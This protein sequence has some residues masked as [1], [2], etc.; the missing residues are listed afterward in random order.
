[1]RRV[2]SKVRLA[3][4]ATAVLMVTSITGCK[5]GYEWAEEKPSWLGESIYD[6]LQR[7]GEFSIFLQ[8]VTDL[9]RDEF[10]KK[11]GSVTVFAATDD[12]YRTYFAKRGIDA[13]NL[14][15]AQKKYLVNSAML[16]NA[17]VLDLLTNLSVT[18]GIAKGQVMRRTNTQWAVYD[19]ITTVPTA[20]LPPSTPLH[21]WWKRLRTM[22]Q[23]A[24]NIIA[25]GTQPMVHFLWR[26]MM[27]KGITPTDFSYLFGG[28]TFNEEDVY[29]NN[30]KVREGNITCQNGYIHIMDDVPTPLPSMAAY[31][32][33]N[34]HT[35]LFARLIDRFSIPLS[36]TDVA[37]QYAYLYDY[38][39]G[40]G[41]YSPLWGGD[42]IFYKGYLWRDALGNGITSV[43][44]E[45][46]TG[47]L[48][49]D[50][51][52]LDYVE[53]GIDEGVDMGAIFAPTD[54]A[55]L[56]WWEG[57]DGQ[58]LRQ[59]YP[60]DTPFDSVPD[61]VLAEFLNNHIQPSFLNSIPSRFGN[62]RDDAK[63]PI[64]LTTDAIVPDA[65]ATCCNGALYVMNEVY[66]PSSFRSVIAPTLV[67]DNMKIMD[68]AIRNLEFKPYLLSM[69]SY[70]NY[71][72]LTDEALRRYIDPVTYNTDDPRWFEFVYNDV[73][74]T[75]DAYTYS[76]DK[77]A[78]GDAAFTKKNMRPLTASEGVAHAAVRNRLTD[79]LN[80]TIIPR[81]IYGTNI[82]GPQTPYLITKDNGVM[83][84]VDKGSDLQIRDQVSGEYVTIEERVEKDNGYYLVA[85]HMV[86][87]TMLSL[88]MLL[89]GHEE[90]SEF[91]ELLLGNPEWTPAER[92]LYA[93][94][95]R[96]S[97]K[98][99][100]MNRDN[101]TV[102]TFNSYQYTVY[103]PD[104]DAMTKAYE[105]G[106]PRWSDINALTE[107]YAGRD[108]IDIAQLKH[109]YTMRLLNFIKYHLQDRSIYIGGDIAN[110]T[111]ET[112]AYVLEGTQEGL[113]YSLQVSSTPN[114]ITVTGNYIPSWTAPATVKST[115]APTDY[116]QSVREYTFDGESYSN[117]IST[118]SYAVVHRISEPLLYD[119]ECLCIEKE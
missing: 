18:D 91:Y 69:V 8:M 95:K 42:S 119:E 100:S 29:I 84:I 3:L 14:T 30:V 37:K 10:L 103:V 36:A 34:G 107:K 106:L 55:L 38:Y 19:S 15:P 78:E 40:Q 104:N 47:W 83:E 16:E 24:Y 17:Y 99:Y 32:A 57:D 66:A 28:K 102:K 76:Y 54:E 9:G 50:P 90:Y 51:G 52:R 2:I 82:V 6:E 77:T 88:Q 21:D 48:K 97:S 93:I 86:Q 53:S 56:A 46:A 13:D 73:Q 108:D 12:A 98:T 67:E 61:N 89:E 81:D 118:S 72:I 87:P 112:A 33:E 94:M 79:L 80:F 26:Q 20:S 7:R 25:Q 62:V 27:T 65:T 75:V 63:D 39:Q 1:M 92:N 117:L 70:Y 31:M 115:A 109:D 45:K 4:Y 74:Q 58:F 49:L 85:D 68:W 116:N 105:H 60:S 44:N 59:R 11:T 96:S 43:G 23:P 5:D 113:S 114:D 111:Y 35:D 41:L 64:G 71:I 110:G 101:T 22:D